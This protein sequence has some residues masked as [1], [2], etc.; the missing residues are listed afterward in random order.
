[1]SQLNYKGFIIKDDKNNI[2]NINNFYKNI[3][4]KFNLFTNNNVYKFTLE[5]YI[6]ILDY[7]L[8]NIKAKSSVINIKNVFE[9]ILRIYL[10]K[11][12]YSKEDLLKISNN[13]KLCEFLIKYNLL[14]THP[15]LKKKL[16]IF[17]KFFISRCFQLSTRE[18]CVVSWLT[19]A[20][21]CPEMIKDSCY[22]EINTRGIVYKYINWEYITSNELLKEKMVIFSNYYQYKQ[23]DCII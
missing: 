2:N 12:A 10:E 5:E 18:G 15:L 13:N 8:D 7:L 11:C 23:E 21:I 16:K 3:N 22:L 14:F 9:K 6:L 20:T 1:M 19:F 17:K 4:I